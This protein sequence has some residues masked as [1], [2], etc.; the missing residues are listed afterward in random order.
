MAKFHITQITDYTAVCC[1]QTTVG[2]SH[3]ITVRL[4]AVRMMT[5]LQKQKKK[6]F[7]LSISSRDNIKHNMFIHCCTYGNKETD[8]EQNH[9]KKDFH[10]G[11]QGVAQVPLQS[12]LLIL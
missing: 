10:L 3:L 11:L 2:S 6:A 1:L 5:V 4:T 9:E 7:A 12:E 8:R